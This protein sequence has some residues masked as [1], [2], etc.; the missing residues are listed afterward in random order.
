LIPSQQN[1]KILLVRHAPVDPPGHLYGSTDAGIESVSSPI[2]KSLYSR[3]SRLP[4]FLLQPRFAL[5]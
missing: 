4:G 1:L 2:S 5:Y 3:L